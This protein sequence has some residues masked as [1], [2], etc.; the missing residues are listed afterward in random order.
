M[1]F[2][3]LI[4]FLKKYNALLVLLLLTG[5]IEFIKGKIYFVENYYS[6]KIYP[7]IF[8]SFKAIF[9]IFPFSFGDVIYL[10]LGLCLLVFFI[11][12]IS[13]K[14]KFLIQYGYKLIIWSWSIYILFSCIW[15]FNYQRVAL[16]QNLNVSIEYN[17]EELEKNTKNLICA[18]NEFYFFL[19][20]DNDSTKITIPYSLKKIIQ[21]TAENYQL[22][23][24]LYLSIPIF[25]YTKYSLFSTPLSYMGF[26]GYLNP[27]TLE[28][29]VNKKI[30]KNTFFI[31]VAH[32]MAHQF[33]IAVENEANFIAFLN[34]IKHTDVYFKYSASTFA[35]SYFYNELYKY[36]PEQA[37]VLIGYLTKGVFENYR[38]NREFWQKYENPFEVVFEKTYDTYLKTQGIKS[39]I[40][41]YNEIV[42]LII[43]ADKKE[44]LF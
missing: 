29:Q 32:E 36:E 4:L 38:E 22:P 35:L 2:F 9:N 33:G 23:K 28:S 40:K 44:K 7:Y 31:T 13:S 6:Q 21:K 20:P 16:S 15:G 41:N 5:I 19:S 25:P 1:P 42:G 8:Y 43:N 14:G 11:K 10:L 37:K 24:E 30:P 34:G 26:T 3:K 12:T 39:G 17:L 27:L 18:T